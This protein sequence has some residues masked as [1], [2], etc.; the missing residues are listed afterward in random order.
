M[1]GREGENYKL[2]EGRSNERAI[3][4]MEFITIAIMDY[5]I[6]VFEDIKW[7]FGIKLCMEDVRGI[8]Q[9]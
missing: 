9:Q 5:G 2:K 7:L 1:G 4:R 6:V 3:C 8:C